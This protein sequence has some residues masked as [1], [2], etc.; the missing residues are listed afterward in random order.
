MSTEDY[1]NHNYN[2]E[3]DFPAI[4]PASN[5]ISE[6]DPSTKDNPSC[7]VCGA[8]FTRDG[9]KWKCLACGATTGVQPASVE[10][11]HSK[12]WYEQ[13]AKLEEGHDVSAYGGELLL[14]IPDG[15]RK[16]LFAIQSLLHR[17]SDAEAMKRL[18]KLLGG[19]WD[20]QPTEMAS[21]APEVRSA[22]EHTSLCGT[23]LIGCTCALKERKEIAALR[24]ELEKYQALEAEQS[25]S[26]IAGE[27]G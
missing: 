3:K 21:P 23:P 24:Q 11:K 8:L 4:Q 6:V 26:A 20:E 17:N 10:P 22:L 2:D 25:P 27:A 13:K 19:R 14:P 15:L 7:H 1:I 18:E 16:E 5:Y 9:N 12:Q